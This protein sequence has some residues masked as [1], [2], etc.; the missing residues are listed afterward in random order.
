MGNEPFGEEPQDVFRSIE[1]LMAKEENRRAQR[2]PVALVVSGYVVFE[3][4]D[5]AAIDF[6]IE[7][8]IF[9]SNVSAEKS[10]ISTDIHTSAGALVGVSLVVAGGILGV[11]RWLR[12]RRTLQQIA[13]KDYNERPE[14]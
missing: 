11:K 2:L 1:A 10:T 4:L 13:E 8:P 7:R 14:S 9:G 5:D 12:G 3:Q 6:T